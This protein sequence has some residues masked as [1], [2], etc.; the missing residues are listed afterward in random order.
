TAYELHSAGIY[1]MALGSTRDPELA[2]DV[3]QDA[4]L[5]LMTEVQ[6]GRAPDNVGGWLYRA[7]T[8]LIVSRARRAAVARRLA[9]RLLRRDSPDQPDHLALG[10]ERRT[11]LGDA[12]ASLATADRVVLM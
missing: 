11:E 7:T 8:N 6:R 10:N 1:G 12:L 3:T 4:F 5:R 2:A 9:P